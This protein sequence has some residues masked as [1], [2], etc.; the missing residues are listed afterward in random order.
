MLPGPTTAINRVQRAQ[1]LRAPD[2]HGGP[3]TLSQER[4]QGQTGDP[5]LSGAGYE[6]Y[7]ARVAVLPHSTDPAAGVIEG[8]LAA[9]GPTGARGLY[10]SA[11]DKSK[12]ESI[13]AEMNQLGNGEAGRR[14]KG[15][16]TRASFNNKDEKERLLLF[17]HTYHSRTWLVTKS[18]KMGSR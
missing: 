8:A 2:E 15:G 12:Q 4:A 16:R 10:A 3:Q 9:P 13:L 1:D 14:E 18:L 7:V 11:C 5:G 6:K 17:R